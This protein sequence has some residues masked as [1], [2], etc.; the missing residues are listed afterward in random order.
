MGV[1]YFGVLITRILQFRVLHS[2]PLFLEC[3]HIGAVLQTRVP[4]GVL[5]I[6]VPYYI[7]DPKGDPD[8]ENYP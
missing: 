6:R 4:L 8:L 1:P 2:G 7:R 5:F 3:P